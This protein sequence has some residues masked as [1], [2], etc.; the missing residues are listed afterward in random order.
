MSNAVQGSLALPHTTADGRFVLL[1]ALGAGAAARVFQAVDPRSG[2]QV[3]LKVFHRHAS[4]GAGGSAASSEFAAYRALGAVRPRESNSSGGSDGGSDGGSEAEQHGIPAAYEH[5]LLALDGAPSAPMQLP[6]LSM[7]LLG[8]DLY[9][10]AEAGAFSRDAAGRR[11][12]AAAGLGVLRALEYMHSHGI[13]HGDVKP[14]ECKN[15]VASTDWAP[16][17]DGSDQ[18]ELEPSF[19]VIDLGGAVRTRAGAG[20]SGGGGDSG[21]GAGGRAPWVT[22]AFASAASLRG[23]PP[24]PADDAEA[25]LTVML[26]LATGQLPWEDFLTTPERAWRGGGGGWSARQLAAMADAKER[27][28]RQQIEEGNPSLMPSFVADAYGYLSSA[29][30]RGGALDYAR[31]RAALAAAADASDAGSAAWQ[32]R[33]AARKRRRAGAAGSG[34]GGSGGGGGGAAAAR[35][36]A[37]KAPRRASSGAAGACD[38]L[39]QF[40]GGAGEE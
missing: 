29:G 1:R 11:R 4:S 13:V 38:G 10:L 8:P 21:A 30:R 3:A 6:F 34:G 28:W 39:F 16:D 7:S 23:E 37:G 35:R 24:A 40:S 22:P 9:S 18:E 19:F 14:G 15:I 17:G 12:L 25:L 5:G 2:Q 32:A 26:W 36:R 20:R 33:A 27:A 31:L